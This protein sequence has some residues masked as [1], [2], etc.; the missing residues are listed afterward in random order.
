MPGVPAQGSQEMKGTAHA[1][2]FCDLD[3]LSLIPVIPFW[4]KT[5]TVAETVETGTE[6]PNRLR[7][8]QTQGIIAEL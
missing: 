3:P 5:G 7:P 8:A 6:E 4:W 1:G 2:R